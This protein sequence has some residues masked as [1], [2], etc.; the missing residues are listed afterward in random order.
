MT[1]QEDCPVYLGD[2]E[3][4]TY[5]KLSEVIEIINKYVD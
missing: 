3:V 1:K 2:K 4:D 5:V